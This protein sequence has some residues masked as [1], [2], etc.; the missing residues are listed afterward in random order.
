MRMAETMLF[1]AAPLTPSTSRTRQVNDSSVVDTVCRH[2]NQVILQDPTYVPP[3]GTI[4]AS[5]NV[6]QARAVA[7]EEVAEA[8]LFLASSTTSTAENS[9][10]GGCPAGIPQPFDYNQGDGVGD[11]GRFKLLR[12]IYSTAYNPLVVDTERIRQLDAQDPS[13]EATLV[14]PSVLVEPN[15]GMYGRE[16]LSGGRRTSTRTSR[17][18][19]NIVGKL[20]NVFRVDESVSDEIRGREPADDEA[21]EERVTHFFNLSWDEHMAL[22]GAMSKAIQASPSLFNSTFFNV[23]HV[24]LNLLSYFKARDQEL[25]ERI[26]LETMSGNGQSGQADE[27]KVEGGGIG[28]KQAIAVASSRTTTFQSEALGDS[29]F[30]G[31]EYETDAQ[32]QQEETLSPTTV[33]LGGSNYTTRQVDTQQIRKLKLKRLLVPRVHVTILWGA[34]LSKYLRNFLKRAAAFDLDWRFFVFCLDDISYD[35]CKLASRYEFL[36]IPGTVKTIY[37]KYVVSALLNRLGF[38]VVYQDF[39]TVFMQDPNPLLDELHYDH[40]VDVVSGRDFGVECAN[41]GILLLKATPATQL[42]LQN[43]LI[44]S[45][46]HPYEF[47]QKTFASFFGIEH[48]ALHN[49]SPPGAGFYPDT[50]VRKPRLKFFEATQEV[51]TR[52]AYGD[53]EGWFGDVEKIKVFHYVDGTGGVDENLAVNK[54]Y[55]NAFEVFYD[56]DKLNLADGTLRLH[57]QDRGIADFLLRSR[58]RQKEYPK[59][60]KRCVLFIS[61]ATA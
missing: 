25:R 58:H 22:L 10:A 53:A 41:T 51:V 54:K 18:A 39:D 12:R 46:W 7:K 27:S 28:I 43:W 47:S 55:V 4:F 30:E 23:L 57:I 32:E 61:E 3:D 60:L 59:E 52:L 9:V 1:D 24:L 14:G 21:S 42:F 13:R 8:V 49:R 40:R 56:N 20:L 34:R 6:L 45:W 29:L 38:D 11:G 37:N 2:R 26:L 31:Q 19:E 35:A 33:G 5:P 16:P 50:G 15:G 17:Q 44:W 48:V 36:C